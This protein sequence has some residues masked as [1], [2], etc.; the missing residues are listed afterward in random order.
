MVRSSSSRSDKATRPRTRIT[1]AA[2]S[3]AKDRAPIGVE[4]AG[5]HI[6]EI[7]RRC[8]EAPQPGDFVPHGGD[9]LAEQ[10]KIAAPAMRQ[11]AG[12]DRVGKMPARRDPDPTVVE[13]CTLAVLGGEEL[14]VDRAV[15]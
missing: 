7:E 13:E 8:A 4:A 9:F 5:R 2:K 3:Q 1:P 11:C 10:R 14:V 6:G 15:D 12:H